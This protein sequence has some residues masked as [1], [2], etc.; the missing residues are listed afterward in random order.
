MSS[1]RSRRRDSTAEDVRVTRDS[2]VV[3]LTDG[4]TIS[5][6]LAWYP[7]LLDGNRAERSNWRLIGRGTGI[8]WSDLDED[9]SV[10]SLLAGLPSGESSASL[11]KWMR[12]RR[13]AG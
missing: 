6:P 4:R 7:R 2:V 8:H 5:V 12:G 13:R 10:E 1:F 9:L 3:D 11:E